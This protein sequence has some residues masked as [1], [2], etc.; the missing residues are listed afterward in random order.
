MKERTRGEEV[1]LT[2]SVGV[3][4]FDPTALPLQSIQNLMRAADQA[5]YRAKS[6]GRNQIRVA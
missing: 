2:V 5:L 1:P 6:N 4:V 3:A